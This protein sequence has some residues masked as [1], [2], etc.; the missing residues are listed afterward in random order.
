MKIILINPPVFNDIGR[1]LAGT[2][3]LG[4]LYI[5][6]FLE[7]NGYSDVR[8][9]DAD[10]AQLSWDSLKDLLTKE[11]PD[12]IG[13]SG[14]SFVLPAI[15]K[16]A[17]IVKEVLPDCLVVAGGFGPSK[18]P[19]KV[20]RAENQAINFVVIG[21]GEL[22]FLELVKN[23]EKKDD[24]FGG[25][26]GL[27]Y[28]QKDGELIITNSREYIKD[29]DSLPWP[30]YHLLF[31][32]FSSY[33]GPNI[34]GREL[35]PPTAV[36]IGSRGCPHRCTFCS[37]GSKM[38]RQRNPKD[39][40]SEIDFYEQR[41]QV[42]SIQFYDDEFIGLSSMQN[43]WI[44]KICSEIIK[45]GLQK[46]LSFLV[47][48]RLSQF[49]DLKTLKKMREANFVWIWWGA[50][51]GSQK[52]LDSIKK[53]IKIENIIKNVN[54]AKQA[55][56]KSLLYIMVGFPGET[57]R[58]I[59]LTVSLIKKAKADGVRIHILS[60]FPGSEL[61]KYFEEHSLLESEDYYKFDAR[62]N[63]IHHTKEM[64]AAEIKEHFRFLVFRFENG[65]WYSS[66]AG[67]KLLGSFGGWKKIIKELGYFSLILAPKLKN[68]FKIN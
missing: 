19:E 35:S 21:E 36:L 46:K 51:S 68:K 65:Y 39:I 38:Y 3:P 62:H 66:K 12:I 56:I 41:F 7:K 22:T 15:I 4:L 34:E 5:A 59:G 1:V 37:L 17:K 14:S 20:L 9:I 63:V 67:L 40:V 48:G 23:I 16:M 60:P 47:Q 27:A 53:D 44:E 24:A 2:P 25:V 55:G 10:A 64:S 26:N 42:K 52:I 50:E 8:V 6:S 18:E 31:P 11:N 61:R 13:V 30:A 49:V 58:D 43:E 57:V 28:L 32:D 29:L 45:R 54:L 33:C